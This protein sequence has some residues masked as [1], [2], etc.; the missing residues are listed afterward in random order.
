MPSIWG[1][2]PEVERWKVKFLQLD[3]RRGKGA[4]DPLMQTARERRADMLLTFEQHKW[5]ENSARYQD[6]SRRDAFILVCSPDL[7]IG[8]F[9]ATDVA[10]V[11]G[12][13]GG[14]TCV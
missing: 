6:A 9:L 10:F 8:D 12:G 1:R 11:L 2:A 13:G 7:S 5:S 4:Q 14:D 3:F